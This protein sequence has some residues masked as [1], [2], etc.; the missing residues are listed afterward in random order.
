MIIVRLPEKVLTILLASASN[1]RL[2]FNRFSLHGS[3]Q[4]GSMTSFFSSGSLSVLYLAIL[5]CLFGSGSNFAFQSSFQ[6]PIRPIRKT[7]RA[8]TGA[9]RGQVKSVTYAHTLVRLDRLP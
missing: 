9:S 3:L 8:P 5:N 7:T 1:H 6:E 2:H 4:C